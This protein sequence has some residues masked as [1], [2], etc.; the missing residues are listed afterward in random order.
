[1]TATA[2]AVLPVLFFVIMATC[3]PR[4][5]WRQSSRPVR[6]SSAPKGV[7]PMTRARGPRETHAE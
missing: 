1:M 4:P 6:F 3:D 5:C 2:L 7:D